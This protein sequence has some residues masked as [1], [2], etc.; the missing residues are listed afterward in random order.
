[1]HNVT[2]NIT[3]TYPHLKTPAPF[4]AIMH[5]YMI[6]IPSP[7]FVHPS[8]MRAGVRAI[9]VSDVSNLYSKWRY[10]FNNY[11]Q[12]SNPHSMILKQD[13]RVYVTGGG[14]YGQ[15]GDGTSDNNDKFIE[16]ASG[17]CTPSP[18]S[19]SPP[20]LPLPAPHTHTQLC[21]LTRTPKRSHTHRHQLILPHQQP[22]HPHLS[23]RHSTP[24]PHL[25]TRHSTPHT[26][27]MIATPS[28]FV[29]R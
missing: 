14:K 20:Y 18:S 1:M 7:W 15:L 10:P 19:S 12:R 27:R 23:I 8:F 5:S 28:L 4:T 9:A 24:H 26:I 25:T 16:V 13:G 29:Y 3:F 6:T 21:I 2:L 11:C 22:P 17:E